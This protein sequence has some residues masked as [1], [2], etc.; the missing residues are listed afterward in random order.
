MFAPVELSELQRSWQLRSRCTVACAVPAGR[1]GSGTVPRRGSRAEWESSAETG[2]RRE[3]AAEHGDGATEHVDAKTAPPL[4]FP[5]VFRPAGRD[6]FVFS[7]C[8]DESFSFSAGTRGTGAPPCPRRAVLHTQAAQYTDRIAPAH[9]RYVT[10]QATPKATH[11]TPA[12]QDHT[13]DRHA[14]SVGDAAHWHC[15]ADT[16]L[17]HSHL[18]TP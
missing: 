3:S 2:V 11:S 17:A 1:D 13:I 16:Q 4:G 8:S 14:A 9:H 7:M 12:S 10:T 5:S 18:T 15:V 6:F